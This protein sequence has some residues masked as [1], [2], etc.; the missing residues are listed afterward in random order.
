MIILRAKPGVPSQIDERT[1]IY[2]LGVLIYELLTGCLPPPIV[3]E[4]T[5]GVS[6]SRSAAPRPPSEALVGLDRSL[7]AIV[8]KALEPEKNRVFPVSVY[9]PI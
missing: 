2:A 5:G 1:D 6:P 9:D 7:D 3:I 4:S 8:L